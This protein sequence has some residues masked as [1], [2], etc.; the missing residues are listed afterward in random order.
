M[1]GVTV[2]ENMF[3]LPE[4]INDLIRF[5]DGPSVINPTI[6]N[7]RREGIVVYTHDMS[8]CFKVISNQALL[9]EED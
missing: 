1:Q 6:A 3:A 8:F 5:A 4:N 9:K 2:I 7:I